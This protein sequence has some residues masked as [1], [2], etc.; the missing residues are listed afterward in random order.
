MNLSLLSTE[1]Q[2]ILDDV[3]IIIGDVLGPVPDMED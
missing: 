1:D 2:V 3:R